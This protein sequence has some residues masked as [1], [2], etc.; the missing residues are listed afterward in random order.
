[1]H[2]KVYMEIPAGFEFLHPEVDR[3]KCCLLWCNAINWLKQSG[4]DFN[5]NFDGILKRVG[6]KRSFSDPCFYFL[7]DYV[8]DFLFVGTSDRIEKLFLCKLS[9]Y[10]K[11]TGGGNCNDHLGISFTY[12]RNGF[13]ES[14]K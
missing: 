5:K 13:F 10:M 9:Q 6:F 8:D 7:R 11:L 1:M 4:D 14:K 2:S 3:E 12:E